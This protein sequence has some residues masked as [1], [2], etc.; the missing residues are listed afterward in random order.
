[1]ARP[2]RGEPLVELFDE[3]LDLLLQWSH[4]NSLPPRGIRVV[5]GPTM[6]NIEIIVTDVGVLK[7]DDV[8]AAM[9]SAIACIDADEFIKACGI[10]KPLLAKVQRI[11]AF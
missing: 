10:L 9:N 3:G 8:V 4:G 11:R 2:L 5:E 7:K 6:N 1:Y